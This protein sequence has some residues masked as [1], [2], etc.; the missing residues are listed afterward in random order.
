[1]SGMELQGV[2]FDREGRSLLDAI[3]LQ[4]VPGELV[5]L[6]GPNGAGKSTLLRLL[7]GL[8]EASR[9]RV[10]LDA[11]DIKA[12][13]PAERACQIGLVPQQ[14]TPCWDYAARDIIELAA[15]RAPTQRQSLSAVA[16]RFELGALLERR[17]SALSGGERARVALA[18]VL[19]CQPSVLLADEPG[20]SLD[21][22]HRIRL[23]EL[24]ASQAREQVCVVA[25]H[26][27]ELAAAYCD[28]LVLLA[29][30][31]VQADGPTAQI[32]HSEDLD[33]VFGVRFQRIAVDVRDGPL[34]P[35][36]VASGA[37]PE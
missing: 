22:R 6:V 28:R 15:M 11:R 2:G 1:M 32:A 31:R 5:G 12:L 13:T 17:W 4:L 14:F 25:L 18:A 33:R 10:R 37:A 19:V 9:G 30:G 20:A 35:L 7:A 26:D 23:L 27:L 8:I 21:V 29:D 36:K 24:L 34:L 3:E 16:G